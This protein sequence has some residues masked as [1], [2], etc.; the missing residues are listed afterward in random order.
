MFTPGNDRGSDAPVV[1]WA[2][3]SAAA[4]RRTVCCSVGIVKTGEPDAPDDRLAQRWAERRTIAQLT[5]ATLAVVAALQ[6]ARALFVPLIIGVL[7][8]YTLEPVVAALVLRR[9]PRA[10]A[11]TLV[12]VAT[13]GACAAAA[14][15]LRHQAEVLVGRLP[16][17][18]AQVR[19]AVQQHSRGQGP[20]TQ[21][22]KAADELRRLSD[23]N[24]PPRPAVA[25][26]PVEHQPFQVSD[27]LWSSSLTVT[28]FLGDVLVVLLLAF[29]LLLAGDLFRRRAIEIAG[30]T[31]SQR[32]ITLQILDDISVQ[33]GRYLMLR[34][35][36]SVFVAIGTW[37]G[38]WAAGL[39][40][41]AIWGV[42]AGVLNVVPYVGPLVV[43]A[44]A[45]LAAFLQFQTLTMAAVIAA[46]AVGVACIEAYGVTPFLT[47]R[48]GDMNPAMVFV[49]LVFW[50]WLWGLPGLLLAVPLMMVL[51]SI[52][53]HVEGLQP[54]AVLLR[55]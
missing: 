20:L 11:A 27:Y 52:A 23:D 50:G 1:A 12:F 13:V 45:A 31:L 21:V 55:R 3:E 51:K 7:L 33:I 35:I 9:L 6:V 54:I 18:A 42:I 40:Q 14:Y 53:E 29:Y 38:F 36:I 43:A 44:T 22:Q 17:A 5:I 24:A 2:G 34:V 10:A 25:P 28:G 19:E 8:S 15:L 37:L 32:K 30:P 41:P 47:S 49:G 48:A 39:S 16:G 4:V 26:V 46:I